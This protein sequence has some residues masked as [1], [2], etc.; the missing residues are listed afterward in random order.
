[1]QVQEREMNDD[2]RWHIG[3]G[4]RVAFH[5]VWNMGGILIPFAIAFINDCKKRLVGVGFSI[6]VAMFIIVLAHD[7]VAYRQHR[8]P[9]VPFYEWLFTLLIPSECSSTVCSLSGRAH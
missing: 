4:Q 3:L 2:G 8:R 5:F 6:L 9:V 1:M 7:G